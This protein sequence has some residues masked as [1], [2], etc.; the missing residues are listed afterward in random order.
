MVDI[1][2]GQKYSHL[3]VLSKVP[4]RLY[5][6]KH[7]HFQRYLCRCDCGATVE[8]LSADF[9]KFASGVYFRLVCSK[10]CQFS[11]RL[12]SAKLHQ[13]I[14]ATAAPEELS[15]AV[16]K[17]QIH[18]RWAS[19]LSPAQHEAKFDEPGFMAWYP[20]VSKWLPFSCAELE[21]YPNHVI[22]RT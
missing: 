21:K 19:D 3:T 4:E 15:P 1:V 12:R 17:S 13:T 20:E 11:K 2:I 22:G 16:D 9:S 7:N 10:P 6:S 14:S 8:K 5:E 18:L